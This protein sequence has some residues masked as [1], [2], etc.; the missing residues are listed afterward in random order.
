MERKFWYGI[1][2]TPEWNGRFLES[3]G[4][5]SSI[6]D[7]VHG[8]LK[9]MVIVKN[10]VLTE[11]FSIYFVDKLRYFG[12]NEYCPNSVPYQLYRRSEYIA[13]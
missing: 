11:M 1:W 9:N 13:I 10:T 5:Q 12:C 2:K 3:N 7:F 6:L 8:I 4:R